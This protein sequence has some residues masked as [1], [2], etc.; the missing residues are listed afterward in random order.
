MPTPPT[1]ST[2]KRPTVDEWG[3]Y[4]PERAGLVALYTR[5]SGTPRTPA[6]EQAK[7]EAVTPA[8]PLPK[9]PA[10]R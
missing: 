9:T 7:P 6:G 10:D 4:D 8:L 2:P 1:P 5:L 3:V